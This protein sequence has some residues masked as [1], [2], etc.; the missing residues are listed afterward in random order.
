M[1]N[2]L[3]YHRDAFPLSLASFLHVPG[4]PSEVYIFPSSRGGKKKSGNHNLLGRKCLS[5]TL[6]ERLVGGGGIKHFEAIKFNT[7]HS[8]TPNIFKSDVDRRPNATLLDLAARSRAQVT[9]KP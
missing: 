6:Q 8:L 4:T 5:G 9:A 3:L 2:I 1:A 7:D